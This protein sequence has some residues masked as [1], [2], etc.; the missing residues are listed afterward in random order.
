MEF[1][2]HRD[3]LLNETFL[4]SSGSL[5]LGSLPLVCRR[6]E[7]AGRRE[8]ARRTWK[9]ERSSSLLRFPF[10]L[11]RKPLLPT[12][13]LFRCDYFLNVLR[14]SPPPRSAAFSL[15]VLLSHW[16]GSHV[17]WRPSEMKPQIGA[18]AEEGKGRRGRRGR[19]QKKL[20]WRCSRDTSQQP[21]WMW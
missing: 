4:S 11:Q 10:P 16:D 15:P 7:V 6:E 12:P 1:G 2:E 17:L 3:K 20:G 5:P 14:S 13:A 21:N 18:A 19:L 9:V 8:E